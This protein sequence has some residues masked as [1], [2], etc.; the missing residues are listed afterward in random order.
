AT[1]DVDFADDERPIELSSSFLFAYNF[2]DDIVCC[3][4]A[5]IMSKDKVPVLKAELDS[6]FKIQE[7]SV[8]SM[9]EDECVVLPVGL[10]TQ[11]ASLGY[12]AMRGVIYAKTM[13][14]PLS[15]IVLPP[16]DVQSVF[17]EP[18]KFRR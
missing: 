7:D 10:M 15:D 6:L 1:F 11:F 4:T 8:K 13:G 17:N 3:T 18:A 14:T 2:D 16:N 9:T 5:V 12:G